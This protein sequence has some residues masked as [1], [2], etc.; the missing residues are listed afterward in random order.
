MDRLSDPRCSIDNGAI[1]KCKLC[2][3]DTEFF[4]T[5]DCLYICSECGYISQTCFLV[6]YSPPD[7]DP[8][9][10]YPKP[11]ASGQGRY[12]EIFHW[13]EKMAQYLEIDPLISLSD[14]ERI[15]QEAQTGKYGTAKYFS[16][17]T[18][19]RIL[20]ALKLRKY[21]E[22][23]RSILSSIGGPKQLFP[24]PEQVEIWRKL[25]LEIVHVWNHTRRGMNESKD[26]YSML[27]YNY[28]Q[29]KLME[30]CGNYEHA[31]NYP[32]PCSHKNTQTMDEIM[33]TIFERIGL[34]FVRSTIIQRPKITKK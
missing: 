19:L 17:S 4:W 14:N 13:N 26:R 24:D 10:T 7:E 1:S 8:G 28:T 20:K 31:S 9:N 18:V 30:A 3:R 22:H 23:W 5:D 6:D 2:E 33:K 32:L 29:R 16:R 12:R 25:F 27:S 15:I 11:P 21:R 34:P